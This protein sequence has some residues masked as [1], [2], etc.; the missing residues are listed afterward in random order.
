MEYINLIFYLDKQ[1]I[2]KF[3]KI[4]GLHKMSPGTNIKR[5]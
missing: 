5:K 1:K 3:D 2:I 4:D